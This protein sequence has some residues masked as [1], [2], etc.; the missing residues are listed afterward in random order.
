MRDGGEVANAQGKR[1][2]PGLSVSGSYKEFGRAGGYSSR[3]QEV[4]ADGTA[5]KGQVGDFM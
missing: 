2:H 3:S 4:G 1:G 5:D